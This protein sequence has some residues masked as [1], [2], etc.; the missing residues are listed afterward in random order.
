MV[1]TCWGNVG[2]GPWAKAAQHRPPGVS[3]TPDVFVRGTVWL[4]AHGTSGAH[5]QA[6][7]CGQEG[8]GQPAVKQDL[9]LLTVWIHQKGWMMSFS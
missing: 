7:K 6:R 2:G 1:E 5:Q 3:V 8:N 9:G 4:S